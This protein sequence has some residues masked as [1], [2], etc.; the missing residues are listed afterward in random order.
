MRCHKARQ[1]IEAL[2]AD[3][4]KIAA[5]KELSEHVRQ[6]PQCTAL[7]QA[8]NLLRQDF[9]AAPEIA[10]NSHIPL[11][12][13]KRKV[14]AAADLVTKNGGGASRE[15]GIMSRLIR[16]PRYSISIAAVAIALLAVL[17]IPLSFDNNFGYE[18]AIAG[19]DRELA[20]DE[21]KVCEL[22]RSIGIDNCEFEVGDC[23]QTCKLKVFDLK[24]KDE[25]KVV[26]A[27]FDAMGNCVVEDIYEVD[28]N[29]S[30]VIDDS[31]REHIL[32]ELKDGVDNQVRIFVREQI[33]K[34]NEK[35]EGTFNIWVTKDG[36]DDSMVHDIIIHGDSMRANFTG[37][38]GMMIIDIT[39]DTG[40][41]AS[42]MSNMHT[43]ELSGADDDENVAIL[44]I[45]GEIHEIDLNDPEAAE[46]LKE[47]GM[48]IVKL[49]ESSAG[50]KSTLF[51]K[52]EF[53][54]VPE[55]NDDETVNKTTESESEAAVPTQ[56]RLQQNYPN[57]F[58][59]LTTIIYS[60]PQAEAVRLDVFNI[61]GHRVRT[62]V[63]EYQE[64]GDYSVVWDAQDDDGHKVASGVYLYKIKAG[65]FTDA[66]KMTLMK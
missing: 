53:E 44:N 60:L 20:L 19:V 15:K 3:A 39:G 58:N 31:D 13:L 62:L 5:E 64:A 33:C 8:E 22:L 11:T 55:D 25:M 61:N 4:E 35:A 42:V 7:I 50:M 2:G 66:K 36:C 1:R 41:M 21:D 63:D 23:E 46:K 24:D 59:P 48:D 14:E 32:Y 27:A 12:I 38:S 28:K 49:D 34:L 16:K 40:G 37:D 57:P 65:D 6:C 47:L 9:K 43:I 45:N 18:V 29:G 54:C 17:V 30:V 26:C 56:F 10:H 51:I 52:K